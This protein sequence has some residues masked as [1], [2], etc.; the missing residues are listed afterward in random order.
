MTWDRCRSHH[1]ISPTGQCWRYQ[2]HVCIHTQDCLV[3]V[4]VLSYFSVVPW[5]IYFSLILGGSTNHKRPY[6]TWYDTYNLPF[7]TYWTTY[8]N[9]HSLHCMPQSSLT[10]NSWGE[11][12]H[13]DTPCFHPYLH[14]DKLRSYLG[15]YIRVITYLQFLS[16]DLI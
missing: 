8:L 2:H 5:T 9:T 12:S 6:D 11:I 7:F 15:E 16:S 3:S 10:C 14:L 13:Y 4:S 1:C